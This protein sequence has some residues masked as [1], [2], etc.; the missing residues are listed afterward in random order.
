[1]TER[2][3]GLACNQTPCDKRRP[4]TRLPPQGALPGRSKT[5]SGTSLNGGPIKSKVP[6]L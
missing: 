4:S 3:Q 5:S 2:Q 1:M 6:E